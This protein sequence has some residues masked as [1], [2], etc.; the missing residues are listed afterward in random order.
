MV[1][2]VTRACG[3]EVDL[4]GLLRLHSR[5]DGFAAR[6]RDR[7]WRQACA[8][9]RIVGRVSREVAGPDI[10]VV[11]GAQTVDDRRVGLQAHAFAQPRDEGSGYL[12][13]LCGQSRLLLDNRGQY[14]RFV[15]SLERQIGASLLP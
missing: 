10:A 7:S 11:A 3:D 12:R 4:P 14:Q 13:T 6:E 5:E 8:S 9:I 15:G 1:S 2:P